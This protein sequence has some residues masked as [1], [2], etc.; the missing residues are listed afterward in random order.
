[1]DTEVAVVVATMLVLHSEAIGEKTTMI[2]LTTHAE[3]ASSMAMSREVVTDAEG[4]EL[5]PD[6]QPE[7]A[8]PRSDVILLFE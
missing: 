8:Q 4:A 7:V 1:V 5:V 6:P 2:D 3:V